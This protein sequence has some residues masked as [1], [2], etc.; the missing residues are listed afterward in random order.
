MDRIR[1][2]VGTLDV[3]PQLGFANRYGTPGDQCTSCDHGSFFVWGYRAA[4]EQVLSLA[5]GYVLA[6]RNVNGSGRKTT[7]FGSVRWNWDVSPDLL[8]TDGDGIPDLVEN[9]VQVANPEQVHSN[10]DGVGDACSN[11]ETTTFLSIKRRMR[12]TD[13]YNSTTAASLDYY[14]VDPF[15]GDFFAFHGQPGCCADFWGDK[16]E[17]FARRWSLL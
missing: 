4:Q 14:T 1:W 5:F 9:C 17:S 7:C 15:K 2:G 13:D 11:D 6:S 8:D 10:A 12:P 16:V 3:G